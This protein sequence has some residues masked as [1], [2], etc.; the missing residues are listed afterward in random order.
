MGYADLEDEQPF[1]KALLAEK[2]KNVKMK[3]RVMIWKYTL[4]PQFYASWL[5]N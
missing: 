3:S 5:T 4:R 1:L 2:I